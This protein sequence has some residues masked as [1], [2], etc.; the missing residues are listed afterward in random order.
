MTAAT[1]PA[2]FPGGA[3]YAATPLPVRTFSVSE[4]H[5]MIRDGYFG[6]DERFELLEGLIVEKISRDPVHDAALEIVMEVL[7]NRLPDGWRVRP[8]CA[9]TTGDSQPEPD[10]AVVRG[11]PRERLGHHPGPVELALVVEISNTSLAE[12]RDW[13]GRIYA[14]AGIASYWVINLIDGRIEAY[15]DPSG[16]DSAPAY[17]RRTDLGPEAQI[18][19]VVDGVERGPIAVRD[20]LP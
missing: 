6:A 14:R 18:P 15:S 13:K 19:F 3:R 20:L 7:R 2:S 4:Y 8:Q 9:I 1:S 5:R 11:A 10:L 17:R 12:D 16:A